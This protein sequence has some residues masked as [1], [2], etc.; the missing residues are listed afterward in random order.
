M[1]SFRKHQYDVVLLDIKMPR[2]NGIELYKRIRALDSEVLICFLTAYE[3]Y[4][5][6]FE[7]SHPEEQSSCFIPKPSSINRITG[8]I[9]N[10]ME[11]RSD[12]GRRFPDRR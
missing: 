2:M 10:K 7:V 9:T 5:A 4:R 12:R 8:I 3:N 11:G 6:E 1:S